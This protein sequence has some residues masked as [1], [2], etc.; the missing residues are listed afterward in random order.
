MRSFC[1][2]IIIFKDNKLYLFRINLTLNYKIWKTKFKFF[3]LSNGNLPHL[4][5]SS[6]IYPKLNVK[7]LFLN[8]LWN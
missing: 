5:L 7:G 6:T 2:L 1:D 4:K 3:Y 8:A